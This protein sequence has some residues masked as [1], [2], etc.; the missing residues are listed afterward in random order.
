ME[1]LLLFLS[2]L[3]EVFGRGL[4]SELLKN[5]VLVFPTSMYLRHRISAVQRDNFEKFVVFSKCTKLY[6]LDEY[7]ERKHG[8]VVP[9]QCS[10]I[11]FPLG[12]AKLCRTKLVNKVILKNGITRFYPLKVY[13]SKSIIS[14][15]ESILGRTGILELCE[16]WRTRLVDKDMMGM[17]GKISSGEMKVASLTL[18]AV[19]A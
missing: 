1:W 5:I 4:D 8:T 18:N 2:R 14:Q 16:E 12:K 17:R 6:H 19:M 10:N 7:L 11:L 9:K 3:L 15:L 13:C